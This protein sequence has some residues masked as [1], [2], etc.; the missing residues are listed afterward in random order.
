[1]RNNFSSWQVLQL[2]LRSILV[3]LLSISFFDSF[4]QSKEEKLFIK[5]VDGVLADQF[6]PSSPGCAVLVAKKGKVIYRKAFGEADLELHVP[7][8]PEMIFRLGSITKQFTAVAILQLVEQG[9]I[10][11]QDNLQKFVKDFPLAKHPVT[12]ENLLTHTSGITDYTQLDISDPFIRRKDFKPKEIVDLFKNEPLEFEPG[13]KFKYSN[14]NYFL[15]GYILELV[16][17]ED[18]RLIIERQLLKPIGLVNTSYESFS[19][20]VQGRT[21]GYKQE[22]GVYENADFQ[23]VTIPF[24]AGAL[25]SN[26]DD[27]FKWHQSLIAFQMIKKETL[28]LAFKPF[29]FKDGTKSNYGFGWFIIDMDGAQ[30]VQHGGNINGFKANEIY[31][32]KED[33]FV[34]TLF[35]CECAASQELSE[36]IAQLAIG[37]IP[38]PKGIELPESILETYVGKFVMPA[39]SNRPIII[40]K[41]GNRLF[42]G[43]PR[44]WKAEL[45][46]LTDT[47]FIVKNI[48]PSGTITFVK[49]PEG[50][51]VKVIMTQG[52]KDYEALRSD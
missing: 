20:I 34:A 15:L 30:T 48:R 43:I 14:S 35:N 6:K 38:N 17:G 28:D 10:S 44:E 46:A 13:T 3:F 18:Y 16:E 11:L 23:S 33:V 2:C 21:K 26:V 50:K 1:M 5:A 47:K 52:G 41:E 49:N 7:V 29:E 42:A 32:P 39:D 36:Q 27:L 22:N 40:S 37:K 12:I 51:V 45:A 4:C 19:K 8:R 25:I 9:K 31:F 24:A